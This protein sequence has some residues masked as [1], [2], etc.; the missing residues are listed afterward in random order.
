[1]NSEDEDNDEL[2]MFIEAQDTVWDDVLSELQVGKKTSHWMWFVFPQLAELG[3]SDM[4][5]L[6]G[7]EDLTEAEAYLRNDELKR[8][9]IVVSSLLLEHAGTDARQIFGKVDAMKLQSCMTLFAAVP[10]PPPVFQ[11]VLDA[12]YD[13]APCRRTTAALTRT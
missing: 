2:E 6:Y 5:Q 7:L 9:L 10:Q 3:Q 4:S 11:R 12:F 1:M 13:G 8:R